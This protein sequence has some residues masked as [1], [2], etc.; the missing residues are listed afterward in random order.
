EA[1]PM[2]EFTKKKLLSLEPNTRYKKLS[3]Q[4]KHILLY[5]PPS[6]QKQMNVYNELL[7]W[8]DDSSSQLPTARLDTSLIMSRYLYWRKKAC[9]GP[10]SDLFNSF[11]HLDSDV[12]TCP[13]L[14]WSILLHNLRSGYNVGS[15]IRTVD[16]FGLSEVHVSGYTADTGNKS[17]SSSAMGAEKWV[18]VTRWESPFE[19]LNSLDE[20]SA[21]VALETDPKGINVSE[22]LWPDTGIL[23]VGNEELGIPQNLLEKAHYTVKIPM[24]GR[25]ASLNVGCALSIALFHLRDFLEKK[26]KGPSVRSA[27]T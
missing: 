16:C 17:L 3:D 6:G 7:S 24:A 9:L 4:V 20:T 2:L 12:P 21:V 23:V 5:C 1:I 18:P 26:S 25:K 11:T 14:N 10:E 19:C 15:A 8:I 13:P 22:F 27:K